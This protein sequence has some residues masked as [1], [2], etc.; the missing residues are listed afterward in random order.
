MEVDRLRVKAAVAVPAAISC[1]ARCD[2]RA[3]RGDWKLGPTPMP[4]MIYGRRVSDGGR[5]GGG[6]ERT[7]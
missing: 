3:I 4:A 2:W 7:W 6:L 1:P 5:D